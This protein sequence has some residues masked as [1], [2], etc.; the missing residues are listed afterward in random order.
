MKEL[1]D[2]CRI[3]SYR[4]IRLLGKGG[5]GA[6]YEVEHVELGTHYALK[7]F[8]YSADTDYGGVLFAKFCEEAKMLSRISH[9]RVAHA[10]DLT[11]DAA[12]GVIYYVMDLVLYKDG[13]S[14]SLEEVDRESLDEDLVYEW[15]RDACEALDHIHSLG[16]VHRDVKLENFLLD[17]DK[18]VVLAD[19]GVSRI[20]GAN[21]K[22]DV[23]PYKTMRIKRNGM[24]EKVVLGSDHYIA[25]EVMA[26]R[27]AT[28]AAD[29]YGLGVMMFKLFADKW[30][31]DMSAAQVD[32]FLHGY[33]YRWYKVVPLLLEF[34]P[35]K[36]PTRLVDL[37]PLLERAPEP[38]PIQE[39]RP[40]KDGGTR[41][42]NLVAAAVGLAVAVLC[43]VGY[44]GWRQMERRNAEREHALQLQIAEAKKV[45]AA[46]AEKARL[47][48]ENAKKEAEAK[49]AAA[50]E[51]EKARLAVENAKK[52]AEAKRAAAAEAEKA[53]LAAEKAMKE[54]EAK[55]AAA[56]R[57]AA[58]EKRI[59]E[60]REKARLAAESAAKEAEAKRVAEEKRKA[61]A[62]TPAEE[63]SEKPDVAQS[64]SSAESNAIPTDRE[65]KAIRPKIEELVQDD[66]AALKAGKKSHVETGDAL[67]G[68]IGPNDEAA[69][70][71]VFRQMAFRQY[72]AGEA[73][74]RA[75]ELYSALRS[76]IGVE[77]AL[78]VVADSRQRLNKP[79][80][81]SLKDRISA[82]ERTVREL[83]AIKAQI[84]KSPKDAR[85]RERLAL[86][87]VA[88]GDWE[89]ALQ[90]F[91][92]CSGEVAKIAGW[93]LS[94]EKSSDFDAAK[95]ARFW[96]AFAE[97]K[98]GRRQLADNMKTH[99]VYWYKVAI[100]LNLLTGL[101]AK[102][103]NRRIEEVESAVESS[104]AQPLVKERSK[105]GFYMIVDL[106]RSGKNWA[107]TYL[108]GIPKGGWSDEFKTKKIVLR[109]IEP[110]SFEY[111][112]GNS[113]KIT[114]P[115]YIGV[116]EVTQKQYE[117][118]MKTNPSEFKGDMRPVERVSYFNIRGRDKGMHWPKDN[119][120]DEDSY[121]GKMRKRFGLEFD[122]PTE[123]QW[124]YAC[125]A[126]TKGDF[127][128]KGAEM[129]K[130]GK[131]VGNGGGDDNHVKVGSF[132][133]NKWGLYDMHGNV[134]EW[135][136]DLW[137]TYPASETDPIGPK[138]NGGGNRVV[139]GG[140]WNHDAGG[141]NSRWRGHVRPQDGH[142]NGG[143]RLCCPAE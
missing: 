11:H 72:V 47:A 117:M 40:A 74:D 65:V 8:T 24:T 119:E 33:K 140:S 44:I 52:E 45:A 121:I 2:G 111:K 42:K 81:L 17:A 108:D 67:L 82:D 75:D 38:A 35:A 105:K 98:S 138:W 48:V 100:A 132:M 142:A 14:Y 137:G 10:F 123:A 113:I 89:S 36:R 91:R 84:A 68:Y 95:V 18:H 115:F 79:A 49:R 83:A 58:E 96:W 21:M 131:F 88:S 66:L 78:G 110:G 85:L 101:D 141:C 43:A 54:A 56:E 28:P 26:G 31:D 50:A 23:A 73:F 64:P 3:G 9:P 32:A 60:E 80:A 127:N 129:T 107:I 118:T 46:E 29:A 34:D 122:L 94:D 134:W 16:I 103:A 139:R 130:L 143:F 15:F 71:F 76:E 92:D 20:F 1:E 70:K 7:T 114:K 102:V 22:E 112:P 126:R 120:V 37:L 27:D 86:A 41:R 93:E 57:K 61:E 59:A 136:K 12:H 5:M 63:T 30:A 124:E 51:A 25:P 125:R 99:A 77:Y 6:V 19:F 109:R 133:P 116:F 39:A 55:R 13:E 87:Y 104:N 4:V 106:T 53:R 128:V 135:C 69:A 97:G 90:A 62:V